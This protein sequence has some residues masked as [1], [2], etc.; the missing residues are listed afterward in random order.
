MAGKQWLVLVVGVV[1]SGSRRGTESPMNHEHGGSSKPQQ[2]QR[3]S[4]NNNSSALKK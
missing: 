2:S 4:V 3:L 1:M